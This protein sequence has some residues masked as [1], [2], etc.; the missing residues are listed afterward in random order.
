VP[1]F[2]PPN[3]YGVWLREPALYPKF[4]V[5]LNARLWLSLIVSTSILILSRVFDKAD[6]KPPDYLVAIPPFSIFCVML[7]KKLEDLLKA[8]VDCSELTPE[9]L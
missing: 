5:S 7:G 2:I 8:L 9:S 6:L 4:W 3:L 1:L